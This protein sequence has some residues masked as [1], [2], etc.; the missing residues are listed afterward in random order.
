M[1][2]AS[3]DLVKPEKPSGFIDYSP[4]QTLA[5]EKM[6]RT[7]ERVYRLFGFLPLQTSIGQRRSVL[8][9]RKPVG[10]ILWNLR[11][12]GSKATDDEDRMV[13][14]RFDLTVPLAR[15]IAENIGT[16]VFPFKRYERGIV[17]RG[18]AAGKGRYCEFTQ[19]DADVAGA[20]VGAA[21]AEVIACMYA[22]MTELGVERFIVRVNNRK[23]LDGFSERVGCA[24]G[25]E[26]AAAL[27]R[28][29]DKIDDLGLEGVLERLAATEVTKRP[30]VVEDEDELAD[31]DEEVLQVFAF[32]EERLARVREFM[33]LGEG[34]A[35]NDERL[36]RL[37]RYFGGVG[38]GA[39]GVRELQTILPLVRA[40][41]VDETKWA[42]DSSIVRGLSYYTGPV[43]ET[44]L[45]DSKKG[46]S[47]YSGGRFDGLVSRFTGDSLPAVGASVGVDRLFAEL[48]EL[49]AIKSDEPTVDAFVISMDP[50]LMADYF[51]IAAELRAAGVSVEIGM[52]YQ[53]TSFKAQIATAR[54]RQAPVVLFYGPDDAAKSVVGVKNMNARAQESVPRADLVKAVLKILGRAT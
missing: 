35:T 29:F 37:E 34:A 7:I 48:E 3:K 20:P 9:G 18:E 25:T 12:D 44:F 36:A 40:Y 21:D 41:G 24:V 10:K 11:A 23:V 47:V 13:T 52:G 19:F 43:F 8:T 26:E 50:G 28:I 39:E 2:D 53:D 4:K 17:M 33:A 49:Q 16:L 1:S 42:I 46:G 15:Y 5:R 22:V 38:P 6:F 51:A 14:A 27:L 32:D 30:I 54:D 31:G 45:L